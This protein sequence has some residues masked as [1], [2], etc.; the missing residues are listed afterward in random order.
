MNV[1]RAA[2]RI[3][4]FEELREANLR[5]QAQTCMEFVKLAA[6]REIIARNENVDTMASLRDLIPTMTAEDVRARFDELLAMVDK[7]RRA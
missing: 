7:L 5:L 3:R 4:A 1:E 6:I 2:T